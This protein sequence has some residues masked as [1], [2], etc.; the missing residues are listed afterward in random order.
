MWVFCGILVVYPC[1][2]VFFFSVQ[3]KYKRDQ[4][5]LQE[6]WEKAQNDISKSPVQQEVSTREGNYGLFH[7]S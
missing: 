5:K 2:R 1:V 6:E 4:E 7:Y 3:E